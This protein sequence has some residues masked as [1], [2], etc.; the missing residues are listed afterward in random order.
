MDQ[1]EMNKC[2]HSTSGNGFYFTCDRAKNHQGLHK[3][4]LQLR[5]SVSI[6]DWGDDG[7]A[8]HATRYPENNTYPQGRQHEV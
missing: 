3:Q 1:T 4:R 8:P 7:L 6:T 2:G 5:D